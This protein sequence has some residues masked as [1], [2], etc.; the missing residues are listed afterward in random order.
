MTAA[1][2]L[3]LL[4]GLPGRLGSGYGAITGQGNGQG[5]REHGLKSDQLPGYRSIEDDAAR[6]HVAAVWG[7]D[8]DSLPGPGKP[9]F[10]SLATPGG[11]RAMLIHGA[12][13]VI[14]LPDVLRL[15]ERVGRP[16]P[17]GGQ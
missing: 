2:S 17:A 6:A 12:N 5:G 9:L 1:I 11:P 16:R 10:E 13:P 7:V 15:T 14:S 3:A 8:P 4:L